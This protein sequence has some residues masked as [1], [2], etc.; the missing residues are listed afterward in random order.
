MI[1]AAFAARLFLVAQALSDRSF[2]TPG[3][4]LQN[5]EADEAQSSKSPIPELPFFLQRESFS[6]E[7]AVDVANAMLLESAQPPALLQQSLA[8]HGPN[9]MIAVYCLAIGFVVLCV[10]AMYY[11][12]GL[13]VVFQIVLY[14]CALAFVKLSVKTVFVG[15]SFF[16]PKFLTAIHLGL[17]SLAGFVIMA[18]RS[19]SSARTFTVPTMAEFC[20][21]ILPIA[22]TF[23][24]SIGSENSAL[25]FCS[26]AFSEVVG[27]TNPVVSALLTWMLGMPFHSKLLMPIGV[28]VAGCIFSVT[29]ELN[30]NV[31]GTFLLVL[32]TVC[33]AFKSVMQ[34]KL[35]TGETKEKFD[36]VSLMAWTCLASM[37][38]MVLYCAVTEGGEPVRALSMSK[39]RGGLCCAILA[40]ALLA[41]ILNLSALFVV[42]QIGAVGMQLVAQMKSALIVIGGIAL[43][44]E[45]FTPKEFVGFG[46]VLVGV[47]WYS[48]LKMLLEPNSKG[49]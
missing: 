23:A 44:H 12:M 42:K 18:F 9:A 43:L 6:G 4:E 20:T 7:D 29:G 46:F 49:H 32:A 48:S 30:F 34:Q 45:T 36:P 5:G 41:L 8:G 27:A 13:H 22:A 35:M 15:Y 3:R 38:L 19:S 24:V 40:S 16:Y 47:Y 2:L 37:M 31:M 17:S 1:R 25:V 11:P 39:D 14:I 26:A 10:T 33:R 21:G 28:V